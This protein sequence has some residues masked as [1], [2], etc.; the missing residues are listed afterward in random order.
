MPAGLDLISS[1]I[2]LIGEM[3]GETSF[4]IEGQVA[5][6]AGNWTQLEIAEEV[7][8]QGKRVKIHATVDAKKTLFTVT[9]R[10]GLKVTRS[11]DSK[12]L[13]IVGPVDTDELT[14]RFALGTV[15][16]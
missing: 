13:R 16:A 6:I 5:A 4:T 14:Y 7:E 1:A 3:F 8:I 2:D 15:N 9:P 10:Q 11:S 12:T